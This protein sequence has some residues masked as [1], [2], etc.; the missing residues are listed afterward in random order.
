M[1][2]EWDIRDI[3]D[4]ESL[5]MYNMD[6]ENILSPLTE[7][8]IHL[9]M[10]I[11][12]NEITQK[13]YKTFYKRAKELEVVYG[14]R[15]FLTEPE[16]QTRM[17]FL[18]EVHKHIGLKTNAEYLTPRKW[19]GNLRRQVEFTANELIA[20]EKELNDGTKESKEVQD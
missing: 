19:N 18:D 5:W 16:N 17:P 10:S 9:T 6:G 8:M 7:V 1:A 12:L 13:N 2:L 3:E 20:R 4:T 11:G 15:G 14:M